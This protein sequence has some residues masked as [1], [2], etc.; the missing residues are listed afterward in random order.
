ML[1]IQGK[2]PRALSTNEV[3][4][5]DDR[6]Q[7]MKQRAAARSELA[8]L[9]AQTAL[10]ELELVDNDDSQTSPSS[11]S[12]QQ[13]HDISSRRRRRKELTSFISACDAALAPHKYLPAELLAY[14]FALAFNGAHFPTHLPPP[15]TAQASSPPPPP[16]PTVT[17]SSP[18]RFQWQM[19]ITPGGPTTNV[20]RVPTSS[21]RSASASSNRSI[22]ARSLHRVRDQRETRALREARRELTYTGMGVSGEVRE[23]EGGGRRRKGKR[24]RL[25]NVKYR[26]MNMK[27][28]GQIAY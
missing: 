2:D 28:C 8:L 25:L 15:P 9:D 3:L 16:S 12:A 26:P 19:V 13:I 20:T 27:R 11:P 18:S 7:L 4:P 23:G 22:E 10:T 24:V 6:N 14:I 1:D 21:N 5:D 17:H